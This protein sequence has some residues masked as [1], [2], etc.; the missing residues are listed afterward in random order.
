MHLVP[1]VIVGFDRDLRVFEWSRRAGQQLGSVD[2]LGRSVAEV[3]P[4]AGGAASW[5]GLLVDGDDV[6]AVWL[7]HDDGR[8][9]EWTPA[10]VR[11]AEGRTI[12]VVCYGRDVTSLAAERRQA[13]LRRVML[14]SILE[15]LPLVA[16]AFARD[17][18]YLVFDGKG[19]AAI[20]LEPGA[21]VGQNAY[22]VFADNA[23][24][25]EFVRSGMD[26][27]AV[28]GVVIEAL[29]AWW[30]NWYVPAPPGSRAALVSISLDVSANKLREQ[31][32]LQ[33]ID[34]IERQQRVI[35][36][37]STP[38]IEVWEGVLALPIIGLVDSVRTS[39]IMDS[40]LQSVG[41][42][43]ARFAILDMTGVDVLDTAT[44][45][46][47]IG[48]IRAVRLLGAEGI[49]TGIHPGVAQTVVT[50]G[51]DLSDITIHATLRQALVYCIGRAGTRAA[52]S[53]GA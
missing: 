20:G 32:L 37:L 11:D 34:V 30:Q 22:Q 29:G 9:W 1:F 14:R 12:G 19:T 21:L 24:V 35:R 41:R 45:N 31:E 40:L 33:K 25:V 4:V 2:A 13:E 27:V 51:V 15:N 5:R 17:G 23:Q 46:H 26:G 38:I 18:E 50:L 52:R 53:T 10:P 49:L 16:C 28:Q 47:L 3:L 8:T 42:M 36:E 39:E 6:A 7:D 44:A 43:R 48:M